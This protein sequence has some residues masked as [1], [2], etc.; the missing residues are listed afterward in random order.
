MS[1]ED[2]GE[3][4]THFDDGALARV[5]AAEEEDAVLAVKEALAVLEDVLRCAVCG[6]VS[7]VVVVGLVCAHGEGGGAGKERGE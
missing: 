3:S 4:R 1:M 2:K 7:G 5:A 6:L